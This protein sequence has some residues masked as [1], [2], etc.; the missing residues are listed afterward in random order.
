MVPAFV[1]MLKEDR[2]RRGFTVGQVAYRIGVSP[3]R[4]F[5]L[6]AGAAWPSF[7]T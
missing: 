1:G 2:R 4:Y 6:E 5:A 7:D 3:R